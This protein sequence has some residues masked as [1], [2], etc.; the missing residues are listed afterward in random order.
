MTKPL[1]V[2]G[3]VPYIFCADA[4]AIADWCV[5]VLGFQERSRWTN[6]NNVITNVE[7]IVGDSEVWLDGPVPDWPTRL[8]GLSSWTGFWVD[9]V[10]AVYRNILATDHPV[11]AP[12]DREF[13]IR[14][15]T[16]RDPEGHEW[17]FIR[18]LG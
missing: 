16:V 2:K 5:A 13:G 11:E 14:Q 8:N 18:R 15:L 3:I 4:G 12:V 17:G 9:D 7:L 6:E 10:D 1:G